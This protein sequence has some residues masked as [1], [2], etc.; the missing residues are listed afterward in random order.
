LRTTGQVGDAETFPGTGIEADA[1]PLNP[2]VQAAMSTSTRSATQRMSVES[3]RPVTYAGRRARRIGSHPPP[4][5]GAV[6][7]TRPLGD[8]PAR[9]R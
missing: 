6:M 4:G 8:R 9:T 2:G 1:G 7:N 5:Q 3:A